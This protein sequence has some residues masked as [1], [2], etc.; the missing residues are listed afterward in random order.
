M[1]E[2]PAPLFLVV[3]PGAS[4]DPD[5]PPGSYAAVGEAGRRRLAIELSRRLGSQGAG[6][7]SLHP[8]QAP[9]RRGLPLGA[10]VHRRGPLGARPGPRRGAAARRHRL[11]R[12]GR[13]GPRRRRAARG[14]H[15]GDPR[16]GGGEQPL[17]DRRLPGRHRAVRAAGHGGGARRP[18]ILLD[19]QRGDPLPRGGRLRVA[20]PG[21]LALGPLRRRHPARPRPP[22]PGDPAAGDAPPRRPGDR[23]P[24]DGLPARRAGPGAAAPRRGSGRCCATPRRSWSWPAGSRRPRGATSRRRAPA[25]CAA[26]SRSAAC[27]RRATPCPTPCSPTGPS[28]S[29]RPT[30]SRS[31]PR[32]ATR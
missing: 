11:C 23:L 26:S 20:R 22:P 2:R 21:G 4:P 10:L 19:R 5:L 12:R 13:P 8:A 14:A 29:A 25:G 6:V 18:G 15:L 1:A 32:S 28:G 3:D 31:W 9:G 17:L 7:A 16:R 27:A 30:W 24:G